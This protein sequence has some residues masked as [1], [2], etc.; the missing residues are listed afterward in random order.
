MFECFIQR[1]FDGHGVKFGTIHK[2]SLLNINRDLYL[3]S[4]WFA[5]LFVTGINTDYNI[6]VGKELNNDLAII[7]S[8]VLQYFDCIITIQNLA[9][10]R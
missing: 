10:G 4:R 6:S 1:E 9:R 5:F 7:L 2:I 8:L 3:N